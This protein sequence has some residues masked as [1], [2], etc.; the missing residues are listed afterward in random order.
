MPFIFKI[1]TNHIQL[2]IFLVLAI[3]F[4][5]VNCYSQ[6]DLKRVPVSSLPEDIQ[7]IDNI[8]VAVRW[9][10][11]LGDNVVV[12]TKKIIK[13][14]DD[15]RIVYHGRKGVINFPKDSRN[16]ETRNVASKQILPPIT[17]HFNIV[18]D[19]AILNWKIV[20]ISKICL[21]EDENH[22]KN[23]FI[24]TDLD[25]DNQSEIWVIS[26]AE[27][28]NDPQL[29]NMRIVMYEGNS[30]YTMNGYLS[31]TSSL[32]KNFDNNF[33]NGCDAFKKY[34]LQL[35]RQFLAKN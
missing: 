29:G 14:D 30:R 9:T 2:R 18:K 15:D 34:V 25:K 20:S 21:G 33:L 23:S 17:Y 8:S 12:V 1:K 16:K 22:T 4:L 3:C 13:A 32:E 31:D 7:R 6:F 24:I 26:K 5:F 28:I 35:W 19:S 11:S 27:C 10:D